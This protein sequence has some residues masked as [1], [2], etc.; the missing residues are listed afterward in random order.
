MK[1]ILFSAL[2]LTFLL[3]SCSES[4]E[5]I[6]IN[7]EEVILKK[8]SDYIDNAIKTDKEAGRETISEILNLKLDTVETLSSR[9]VILLKSTSLVDSA[10]HIQKMLEIYTSIDDLQYSSTPSADTRKYT[11]EFEEIMKRRDVVLDQ[12]AKADSTDTASFCGVLKFDY[13]KPDGNVFRDQKFNVYFDTQL[14][15]DGRLNKKY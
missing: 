3:S 8:A 9:D 1:K 15:L 13:K 4:P 5:E 6:K 2:T 14:E 11:K 10:E 12:I 7:R